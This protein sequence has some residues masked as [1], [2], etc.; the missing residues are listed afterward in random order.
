[1]SA[2]HCYHKIKKL[3][4]AAN[5][6]LQCGEDSH[7]IVCRGSIQIYS[8]RQHHVNQS[9]GPA[10]R[11]SV[12]GS[13]MIVRVHTGS[14]RISSVWQHHRNQIAVGTAYGFPGC[15]SIIGIRVQQG[16]PT[17]FQC[18]AASQ[19]LECS[20][21]TL[22][23]S[24]VWQHHRNQSTAG[25]AY[26]FLVCGSIMGIRVQGQ[27]TD[28]QCVAASWELECRQPTDFQCVAASWELECR[29]SLRISSLWQH[30]GNQSAGA[31]AAYGFP[32]CGS[33]MGIRVQRQPTDFQCVVASQELDCSRDSLQISSVWQHQGNQSA[34]AAYRFPACGSIL[35]IRVKWQPTD[36]QCGSIIGIRVQGSLQIYSV[37]QHHGNQCA[38]AAYGFPV[39][40]HHGN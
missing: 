38:G 37:W 11:F 2:Y 33:I 20:R 35:G 6:D 14:L 15:G 31:E 22:R 28:F 8:V 9:A 39:W 30:H 23:I 24:S 16:P 10:Y 18:V 36:S 4:E 27:P 21:D 7:A 1:M 26:G 34:G 19:E 13:F 25:T 12:C 5:T 17:D 40:Q 32:V 29:D 3:A